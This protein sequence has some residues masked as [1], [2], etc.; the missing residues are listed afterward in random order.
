VEREINMKNVLARIITSAALLIGMSPTLG[1][2]DSSDAIL[3]LLGDA[4]A[5][6]SQLSLEWKSYAK[7]PVIDWAGDAPEVT[8][9]K[10]EVTAVVHAAAALNDARG[11]ASPTQLAAMD[12]IVPV[13]REIAENAT[14]AIDFLAKNQTRLTGKQY[15][16]YLEQSSDTSGRLATLVSQMVEYEG[17][18]ARFDLAKRNLELAAK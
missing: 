12:R 3:K 1:A 14:R 10:G 2:A 8:A 15:K 4:Q 9:M 18:R 6:S 16:D 17:R 11:Q 13:V 5:Q 7:Q